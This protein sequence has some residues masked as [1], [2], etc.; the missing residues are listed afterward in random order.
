MTRFKPLFEP[1]SPSYPAPHEPPAVRELAHGDCLADLT[2]AELEDAFP[3][4]RARRR[5]TRREA[6]RGLRSR[7]SA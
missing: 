1:P 4:W 6:K 7:Q 5:R 2:T 3:G